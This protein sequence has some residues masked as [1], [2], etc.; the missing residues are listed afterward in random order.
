ME[1]NKTRS[2]NRSKGCFFH[3]FRPNDDMNYDP[4]R[5]KP[6]EKGKTM[7]PLLT[8]I[9][10]REKERVALPTIL[11][12]ALKSC[13]ERNENRFRKKANYG[14]L[15]QTLKA[16]LNETSWGKKIINLRRKRNRVNSFKSVTNNLEGEVDKISNTENKTTHQTNLNTSTS[17]MCSSPVFIQ[18]STTTSTSPGTRAWK[19]SSELYQPRPVLVN[20]IVVK[21][22]KQDE[23]YYS[24]NMSMFLPLIILVTLILWGRI[25]AIVCTSIGF[26]LVSPRGRKVEALCG[27]TEFDSVHHKK[28]IIMEGLL[29]RKR[30]HSKG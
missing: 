11:S 24:C 25:C 29:Q 9:A 18:S 27:D 1:S 4:F 5:T 19:S 23:G 28:K 12:S 8:Y 15:R 21:K 17:S 22:H 6:L 13:G 16:T 20:G 7:D 14:F 2:K 3:C 30:C 26:F 10:A